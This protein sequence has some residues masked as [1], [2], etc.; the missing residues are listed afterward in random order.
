MV[1]KT[2]PNLRIMYPSERALEFGIAVL[3]AVALALAFP[4]AGQ[5]WLAPV[6]AAGLFWLWQRL[7]WKRAFFSGWLSGTVFFAVTFWWISFTIGS[8]IGGFAFAVPV[9]VALTE[10][11]AFALA[12]ASSAVAAR[13]A[14]PALAPLAA[15]A[16]FTVFEWLRSI[17]PLGVPFEQLG[18][19]QADTPLGL[20]AAYAGT[21][22][23]TFVICTIGAYAASA[24]ARRRYRSAAVVFGTI[25]LA[26]ALCWAAWPARAAAPPTMRVAAVQGNIAQ[27][28]KMK[29]G[30]LELAIRR[31][32][33]LTRTVAPFHPQ[34]VVWP[35]TVI[36][37]ALDYDPALMARFGGIA[38]RLRTTLV[39]GSWD[40]HA[41][42]YYNALYVFGPLGRLAGIYDK[43]QLVPFAESFPGKAWLHWLPET[44]FIGNFQSGTAD[45]V[46][47]TAA[48]S[49]APLIC[50]ESAFADLAHGQLRNGAQLLVVA[51]D[52]AWFGETSG[53]YQHAQIAQLRAIESGTWVVR[54]AAT[55]ISGII[56]PDGRWT[57]RSQLDHRAVVLGMVGRPP[58]SFFARIGPRPVAL[59]LLALY[60]VLVLGTPFVRRLRSV[61]RED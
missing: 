43:R 54:A 23:V 3:S 26:W 8:F 33:A 7:S 45:S 53:P 4:K 57:A 35:E 17:G 39:V 30:A 44:S 58:G 42:G 36:V 28:L 12:A 18:Y 20:F 15:A 27:S 61:K 9:I 47:P 46:Y 19:T 56:A 50:W 21:Y 60:L 29:P 38:R 51:T 31:Y 5:A 41:N 34:L 16:A 49:F 48:L 40:Y 59:T 6:G 22:G 13:F 10:G 2:R 32:T 1:N 37:T 11:L 24:I 55:G 25:A 52:D 14:P